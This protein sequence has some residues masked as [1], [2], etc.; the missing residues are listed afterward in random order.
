[1]EAEFAR[2]E[3]R[4]QR[5]FVEMQRIV[6]RHLIAI[7]RDLARMGLAGLTQ[8]TY[9]LSGAIIKGVLFVRSNVPPGELSEVLHTA[10][11]NHLKEIKNQEE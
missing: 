10:Y 7:D 5:E 11:R 4:H 2:P 3:M 6:D 8:G 9:I 1:M